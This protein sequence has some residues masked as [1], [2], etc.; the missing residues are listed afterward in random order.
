MNLF[1]QRRSKA[2]IEILP[3]YC[4]FLECHTLFDIVASLQVSYPLSQLG[5]INIEGSEGMTER[6]NVLLVG[7][8]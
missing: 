1:Q 6:D 8:E 2:S 3:H 4:L 7:E 5:H